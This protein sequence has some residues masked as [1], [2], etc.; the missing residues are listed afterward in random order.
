MPD[1]A[2]RS[3]GQSPDNP[4][5]TLRCALDAPEILARLDALARRGKLAGFEKLAPDSFLLDAF[6]NPFDHD[7]SATIAVSGGGSSEP[8][9][10]I[11]FSLRM[12]R[13]LPIIFAIVCLLTIEPGQYFIDQMIPGTW[14]WID[15]Q[16]WYYPLAIIPLPFMWRSWLKKG[17]ASA[18]DHAHEQIG[19]VAQATSA[20]IVGD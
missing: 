5:P 1:P 4:L 6:G 12:R 19:K 17:R 14:G 7:L 18:I 2:T 8:I 9:S 10:T 16:L 13:R 3:S 11:S 15:T 20:V